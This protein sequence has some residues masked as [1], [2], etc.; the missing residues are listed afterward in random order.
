MLLLT[1]AGALQSAAQAAR[2]PVTSAARGAAKPTIVLVHGGFADASG[3]APVIR[4][5]SVKDAAGYLTIDAAKFRGV[6]AADLPKRETDVMAVA[7]KPIQGAIVGQ[8]VQAVAWK[9]I[10]SWYIVTQEDHAINPQLERLY[11]KVI[12]EAAESSGGLAAR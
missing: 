7:Q 5:S 10:P 4:T 1:I 2:I 3:W 9:T 11:A 8:S 12:T 6:F